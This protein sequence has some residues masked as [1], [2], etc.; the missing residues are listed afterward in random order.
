[1]HLFC[2][3]N[4][5][6]LYTF[7]YRSQYPPL[8][9]SCALT[10]FLVLEVE[11]QIC[12]LEAINPHMY[13]TAAYLLHSLAQTLDTELN[14]VRRLQNLSRKLRRHHPKILAGV[15]RDAFM[16]EILRLTFHE[17]W[18]DYFFGTPL[19]CLTGTAA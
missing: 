9:L 18:G 6:T 4:T 1:M 5:L 16:A 19:V 2:K 17:V 12:V 13:I 11:C 15:K 8:S 3:L 10:Q 14:G 7:I